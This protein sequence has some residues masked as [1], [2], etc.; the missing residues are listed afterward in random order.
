M[1]PADET[2]EEPRHLSRAMETWARSPQLDQRA[3]FHGRLILYAQFP[4]L[5]QFVTMLLR[6]LYYECHCAPPQFSADDFEGLNINQRFKFSIQRIEVRWNMISEVHLDQYPV[7]PTDSWHLSLFLWLTN[8]AIVIVCRYASEPDKAKP[9]KLKQCGV[10]SHSCVD[11][12]CPCRIA[13]LAHVKAPLLNLDAQFL[14]G[15][16]VGFSLQQDDSHGFM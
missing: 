12:P 14:G 15:S 16:R 3:N 11:L 5:H 1:Q 9:R 13:I 7:K 8:N 10:L 4:I 6:P 2:P